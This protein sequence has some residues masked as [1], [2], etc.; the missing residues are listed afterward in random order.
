MVPPHGE[1]HHRR[2]LFVMATDRGIL[3]MQ[4]LSDLLSDGR[5]HFTGRRAAR[6]ERR[7]P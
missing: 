2:A 4:D 5:E 1:D 6:H 7:P 3:E